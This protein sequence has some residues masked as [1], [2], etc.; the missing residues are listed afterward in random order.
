MRLG[1]LA[2]NTI[3]I[4]PANQPVSEAL[5]VEFE[6]FRFSALTNNFSFCIFTEL[7]KRYLAGFYAYNR[8][9]IFLLANLSRG[10]CLLLI[11]R[12][13]LDCS[14]FDAEEVNFVWRIFLKLLR[15]ARLF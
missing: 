13:I 6:T 4:E 10:G 1:V 5:T 12:S 9:R 11:V 8:S 2:V 7:E 15:D 14:F 3:T